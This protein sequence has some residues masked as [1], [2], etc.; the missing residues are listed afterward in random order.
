[1][2]GLRSSVLIFFTLTT[3]LMAAHS[4]RANSSDHAAYTFDQLIA[5]DDDYRAVK[6]HDRLRVNRRSEFRLVVP[7]KCRSQGEAELRRLAA[8]ET[9]E[10]SYVY[11]PSRCLWI[12]VG[13]DETRN[14]VRLDSKL[15]A[16]LLESFDKLMIY[17]IHVGVP[18]QISGYF[19]A[20]RDL[21]SLILINAK[22]FQKP[23][24]QISHRVVTKFGV[25]DYLFT[26][27][28]TTNQLIDK[29]SRSGLKR[30][31]AQNLA[32]FYARDGY[33]ER[34]YAKVHQC[35]HLIG[36][37]GENLSDC[38]P[39]KTDDFQLTYRKLEAYS[40]ANFYE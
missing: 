6:L 21:V 3:I 35:E 26:T 29:I 36:K 24:I 14:R 25:I 7:N 10:E 31:I 12:E 28:Q 33:K 9:F 2:G 4:V 23:E 37:Y 40:T 32:Y 22:F 30:F 11:I 27:T 13:Y 16:R 1:M 8:T 18:V 38:F 17:H 19:P 20:Y 5:L 39:M 34:Y 15:I